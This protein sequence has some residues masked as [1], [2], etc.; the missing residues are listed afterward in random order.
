MPIVCK[1]KQVQSFK[2]LRYNFAVIYK[3]SV[4]AHFHTENEHFLM[5]K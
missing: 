3:Y 4:N 1:N 2:K 5:K